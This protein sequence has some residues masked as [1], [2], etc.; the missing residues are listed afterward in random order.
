MTI[1]LSLLTFDFTSVVSHYIDI[2]YAHSFLLLYVS[3]LSCFSAFVANDEYIGTQIKRFL[4]DLMTYLPF[5]MVDQI[6]GYCW[7][8]RT[9]FMNPFF[10]LTSPSFS[11]QS[12]F[13]RENCIDFTPYF[14]C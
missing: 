12:L 1:L 13:S 7:L 4:V 6:M 2:Y 5:N 3:Q 10:F 8:T 14:F 9:K 11:F